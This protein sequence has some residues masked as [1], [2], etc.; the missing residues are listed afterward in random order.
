MQCII[1]SHR[2]IDNILILFD[3]AWIS[4][5]PNDV[6]LWTSA[7]F[8]HQTIVSF[9][10]HQTHSVLIRYDGCAVLVLCCAVLCC[11]VLCCAVLWPDVRPLIA[12]T[13]CSVLGTGSHWSKSFQDIIEEIRKL[14]CCYFCEQAK[15]YNIRSHY[16]C[17]CQ[18]TRKIQIKVLFPLLSSLSS[19]TLSSV[20]VHPTMCER[21]S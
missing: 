17:G 2:R 1:F 14:W 20:N 21:V 15:F 4:P 6:H 9:P 12:S 19:W 10:V 13:L 8:I 5:S 3:I 18:W 7:V 16:H 11:A